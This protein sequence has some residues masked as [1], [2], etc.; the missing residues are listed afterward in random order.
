MKKKITQNQ[1]KNLLAKAGL[2]K[3]HKKC[4]RCN[5]TKP[6]IEFK[7]Y[8]QNKK[9]Y[10]QN[11]CLQCKYK[12]IPIEKILLKNANYR[13]KQKKLE[14]TL[15]LNDIKVPLL[16]P[17]F[18]IPLIPGGGLSAPSLDRIDNS[19][20]YTPDNIIVVSVKAN[21]FKNSATIGELKQLIEFYDKLIGHK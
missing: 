5:H 6:L 17:V 7:K 10:V 21:N 2:A 1:V 13:A 9:L 3:S 8:R 14:F 15:S 12:C 16:C 20:G 18:K 11:I 19:R 4:N